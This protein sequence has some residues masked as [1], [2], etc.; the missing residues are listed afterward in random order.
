MASTLVF[1]TDQ[2][3]GPSSSPGVVTVTGLLVGDI[4]LR[5]IHVTPPY[6][7]DYDKFFCPII[8]VDDKAFMITE[9]SQAHNTFFLVVLRNVP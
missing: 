6:A 4:I 2:F 1:S 3:S 5:A 9:G 7:D 8:T